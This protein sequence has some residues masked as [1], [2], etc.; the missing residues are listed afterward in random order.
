MD[1]DKLTGIAAPLLSWFDKNARTLPWREHP[2]PYYVWVSEIMLQQTRVEA[3]KPFF[4]RFTAALPDV[5]ALAA[6]PEERLLK[7]WEGLGYYN[8]VRNMQRAARLVMQEYGGEIPHTYEELKTLPGIGSYTAGAIASIAYGQAVPA[9]DGNVLRVISRIC[10][11]EE[12]ISKQSVRVKF[13]QALTATMPRDLPGTYNQALMELGATV[14]L[15]NGAPD[16]AGCPVR[17]FCDAYRTG[18][19][20]ELPIRAAKKARRIEERTV[21]VIRDD[22]RA[23]VRR[24]P[25]KGLLAGLYE[26]P[27]C[28]GHLTQDEA[29]ETVKGYGFRPIRILPLASAKHIFSHIEWHMIGYLVLVE[30]MPETPHEDEGQS[31][32]LL[33]AS[34]AAEKDEPD[35]ESG[36]M[37]LFVETARTERDYPIPAAYAAY[38]KYLSIR[39]GQ[40]KYK[41]VVSSSL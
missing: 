22:R 6:C 23:A 14:C 28:E 13:E 21:L 41:E 26:L 16:C 17:E 29:L 3:V 40:E 31:A 7:L 18:R 15:P 35:R 9:V 33:S 30:E 34:R 5:A 38:A 20:T 37:L 4:V 19:Q 1:T 12:D 24:R 36:G 2:S 11:S 32:A 39:L 27:S 25:K 8:R 10:G